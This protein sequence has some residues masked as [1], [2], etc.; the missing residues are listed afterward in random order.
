MR[1]AAGKS[2]R[3]TSGSIRHY[4]EPKLVYTQRGTSAG[5]AAE[6]YEIT[7]LNPVLLGKHRHLYSRRSCRMNWQ[8]LLVWKHFG[9][10]S[11]W[12]RMEVDDG[13]RAGRSGQTYS[14]NC[15]AIPYGATPLLSIANAS[16]I[17][18]P[19]AVIIEKIEGT[20][21]SGLSLRSLRRTTGRRVVSKRPGTFPER[22]DCIQTQLSLRC[23]AR[24]CCMGVQCAVIFSF[25]AAL[26]AAAFSNFEATADGIISTIFSGQSGGVKNQ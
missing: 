18:S 8:H 3:R 14:S 10:G 25:A 21:R 6:S 7:P 19:S 15:A 9:Q 22:T 12:Q 26:L 4:P 2:P 13:K 24:F 5:T 1:R 17:N 20:R 23:G 11:A 16:S